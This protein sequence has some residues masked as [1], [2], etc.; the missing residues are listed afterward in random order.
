M[1][2]TPSINNKYGLLNTSMS[3]KTTIEIK[4]LK[5]SKE[6]YLVSNI[7]EFATANEETR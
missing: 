1:P 5:L 4:G 2:N 6:E 3:Q 7:D